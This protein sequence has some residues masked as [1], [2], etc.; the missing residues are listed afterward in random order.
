MSRLAERLKKLEGA[1]SGAQ[2]EVDLIII[3]PMVSVDAKASDVSRLTGYGACLERLPDESKD[4][5]INRT[6]AT[7]R[8]SGVTA[9]VLM[10]FA[11]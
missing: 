7:V 2:H 3:R 10:V 11:R 8:Q 6:R 4:D 5:F 1:S 9:P